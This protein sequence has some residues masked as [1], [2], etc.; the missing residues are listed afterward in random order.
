[1]SKLRPFVLLQASAVS[2]SIAGSATF[3][4]VPWLSLQV[5]GSSLMSAVVIAASAIPGLLLTTFVGGLVDR[6]GRRR[7]AY[8]IEALT[9]LSTALLPIVAL[10]VGMS[11]PALI[12]LVVLKAIFQPGGGSARKSLLPDAADRAGMSLDRANS[13]NEAL[14]SAGFAIGP[15]LAASLIAAFDS[16][17]AFWLAAAASLASAVFAFMIRV[18]EKQEPLEGD[19]ESGHPIRYA[20]QG[21]VTLVKLPALL[22][23]FAAFMILA[24]IYMPTEMVVLP[25]YYSA[26]GQP[27]QMGY[28]ITAMSVFTV[29]GAL[30]F[31]KA[32]QLLGYANLVRIAS[33]VIGLCMVPM[34]LLPDYWVM[35]VLG[36]ILGFVWGPMMP[37]LNTLIQTMVPANVRGRVFA[38]EQVMWNTAPLTSFIVTGIALDAFG[39]QA[40]YVAL[41]GLVLTASVVLAFAPQLRL[42]SEQYDRSRG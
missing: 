37:L 38:I 35:L 2:S 15:A 41:A 32:H 29:L 20:M 23:V 10:T 8:W 3:I 19:A 7:M 11:L 13:I 17:A 16:Y 24:V 39:V 34:A 9:A 33:V 5:T 36:A 12:V 18:Q 31:E 28:L 22:V 6:F 30:L 14:S 42:L 25:R 1:M 40:V 21:F 26:I 4:A 27:E